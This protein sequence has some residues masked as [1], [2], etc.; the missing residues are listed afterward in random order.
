MIADM[1][2]AV[3]AARLLTRKAAELLDEGEQSRGA[4]GGMAKIVAS[5]TAMQVTTDAVQ[6]MGGYGYMKEY[7]VERMMRDAKLTQIYTGTNQIT[8]LVTGGRS[9]SEPAAPSTI[10]G[11][12]PRPRQDATC[13]S[14]S[15]RCGRRPRRSAAQR[16]AATLPLLPPRA[17]ASLRSRRFLVQ[18]PILPGARPR[19]V[20]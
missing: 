13:E 6:I 19:R 11:L 14:Q 16:S 4:L 12:V 3:E 15:S 9:C 7:G 18:H 5:D 1:A 10:P 17:L 20:A 2:T 8:R